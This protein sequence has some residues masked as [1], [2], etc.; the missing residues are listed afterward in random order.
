MTPKQQKAIHAHALTHPS[1]DAAFMKQIR[2]VP[3][4]PH[5]PQPAPAA[6]PAGPIKSM[7][8]K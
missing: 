8:G 6:G 2:A 1:N 4:P 3:M 7:G 5:S